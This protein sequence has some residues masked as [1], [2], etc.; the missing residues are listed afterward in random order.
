M[1]DIEVIASLLMQIDNL[2]ARIFEADDDCLLWDEIE[3]LRY[4]ENKLDQI[5]G[6]RYAYT[7]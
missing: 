4:L 5:R 6:G 2:K 1:T 7:R 3:Q